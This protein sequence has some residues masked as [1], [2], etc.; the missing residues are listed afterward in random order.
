M[1]ETR[2]RFLPRSPR[3]RLVALA[4]GLCL[5]PAIGLAAPPLGDLVDVSDEDPHS[6]D[7][8]WL[9]SS[10]ITRGCNPPFN[11]RFC[12]DDPIT[13]GQ[14]AA[15]LHR[16]LPDLPRGHEALVTDSAESIFYDDI[17]WLRETGVTEGCNPPMND[18]YCPDETVTRGEMAA[19]LNRA[20]DLELGEGGFADTSDHVF[21]E[22]IRRLA[23]A[24]ITLGCNPPWNTLFCPDDPLT[25]AEM[26]TFLARALGHGTAST[27]N[28]GANDLTVSKFVVNREGV[29]LEAPYC[30]NG[31][32]GED[33][34]LSH[35]LVIVHGD[36][37]NAC[38]YASWGIRSARLAGRLDETLVVAPHFLV[39]DDLDSDSDDALYWTSSSWKAGAMSESDER[40]WEVSSFTVVDEMIEHAAAV[41]PHLEEVVV[42]GH[43]AGGQFVNRYAASTRMTANMRFVVANPSSYLYLDPRRWDGDEFSELSESERDDCS[44][45]DDYKYGLNDLY[46]Y[47]EEV[48]ED[49]LRQQYNARRV[50]YLLG[51]HDDDDSA[52]LLDST[53]AADWQG[54]D[55][56]E[57]GT[58]FFDYLGT[59][60]GSDVYQRHFLSVVPSVGHDASEMLASPQGQEALFED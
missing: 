12:P 27:E 6:A 18:A 15:F 9:A 16:A 36:S 45:Y 3:S 11:D 43:S 4:V 30:G 22:D 7:I 10:G 50:I 49:G 25:R 20:L 37:R 60:Y 56:F 59:V 52:S 19:F 28:P 1:T 24:E 2:I 54:D 55:R 21:E 34:T 48:G 38:E 42:A 39:D 46:E 14:M 31:P 47:P 57:R 32:I 8:S 51:E 58:R 40:P 23:A 29:S 26:A 35:L 5:V 13:R 41:L 33:Q 53:C 17:V 44:W